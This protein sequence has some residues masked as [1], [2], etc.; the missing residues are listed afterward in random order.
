MLLLY[1]KIDKASFSE[2]RFSSEVISVNFMD[3][4]KAQIVNILAERL[5]IKKNDSKLLS[6]TFEV[7][8]YKVILL[9]FS[10]FGLYVEILTYS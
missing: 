2:Q 7:T 6:G 5:K 9:F 4:S 3:W 8:E 10:F 1:F